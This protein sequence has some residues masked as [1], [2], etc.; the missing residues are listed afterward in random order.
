M[1]DDNINKKEL[2]LKDFNTLVLPILLGLVVILLAL[3]YWQSLIP[4]PVMIAYLYPAS[5]EVPN[6]WLAPVDNP[7]DARQVTFST[8]GIYDFAVDT[9]GQ[10]IA[11]SMRSE[12]N[13]TRD[14]YLL[15]LVSGDARQLT[16]CGDESAECYSP[17]FHPIDSVVAYTRL[18]IGTSNN[19]NALSEDNSHDGHNH[20]SAVDTHIWVLDLETGDNQP[21]A[22]DLHLVGHSPVWSDNG[23]TIAYYSTNLENQ[24]VMVY[25]F[26]PQANNSQTLNFVPSQNG[27]VGILSPDGLRLIVPDIVNRN[28]QVYTYLKLVDFREIPVA[29]ENFSD[30][31]SPVDDITAEWHPSGDSVTISRRYTDER[32]TR[33]Y[34]LFEADADTG[35]VTPLL[36]DEN[37]GHY[38]F[39]WDTLGENLLMQRLPLTSQD[40]SFNTLARPEIWILNYETGGLVKIAES[41]YFPRWVIPQ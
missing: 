26:N 30:P 7:D 3:F 23:Q 33:G 39:T 11:Y 32:W 20:S 8:I 25:N 17:V 38:F 12:T 37:Y 16:F 40:G 5:E 13:L 28:E 35:E 10:F 14:V 9:Q 36:Y 2:G 22:N 18:E 24:G 29:F 19:N 1:G 15:D 31:D 27:S 6:I 34:Q 41:A 4:K 21:L